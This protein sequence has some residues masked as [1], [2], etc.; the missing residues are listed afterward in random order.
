MTSPAM[1]ASVDAVAVVIPARDEQD[2]LPRALRHVRQAQRELYATHPDVM[3]PVVVVLDSCRDDT[4]EVARRSSDVIGVEVT[5]GNVGAARAAGIERARRCAPFPPQRV[6]IGNTDA[7]TM[8]PPHWLTEQ[9]ALAA[10]GV[11]L[12]VGSVQPDPADLDPDALAAWWAR[13]TL[14]EGHNHVHGANLGFSLAAHDQVGGFAALATGEDVDLVA[15]MRAAGVRSLAT[16]RTQAITSG[17]RWGRAA[18]GFAD[19][20]DGLSALHHPAPRP[21]ADRAR[22]VPHSGVARNRPAL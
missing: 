12:V 7:D 8:V 9:V 20:L 22:L 19:Y 11:D 1:R 17:R 5:V 14:G 21:S 16:S 10:G 2:L 4:A 6:W 18:Q 13:H 15:R 3:C